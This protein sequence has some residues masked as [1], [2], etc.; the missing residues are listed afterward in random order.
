[1]NDQIQ[2]KIFK[3]DNKLKNT[4]NEDKNNIYRKKLQKYNELQHE[5]QK[6]NNNIDM[7][8][9]TSYEIDDNEGRVENDVYDIY[10]T[11]K[12][13]T[14]GIF[15]KIIDNET[16]LFGPDNNDILSP[17]GEMV[18]YDIRIDN[19]E[20]KMMGL[21]IYLPEPPDIK[22]IQNNYVPAPYIEEMQYLATETGVPIYNNQDSLKLGERGPTIME[23]FH[24]RQKIRHFD[25]EQIPE[26]VVHARGSG[27]YGTF[28]CTK[29]MSDY[30]IANF[31][32]T[33]GKKTPVF[34]R[35]SQ[36]VGSKGSSDTVRDVRGFAT[37]FYTEEGNF[38]IVGND[39]P[40]F[41]I[42][43]SIK[44]PDV[45]HAIKPEPDSAMPQAT[46]AHDNFWDF[47]SLTPETAHM[48]MWVISDIGVM[49]SYRTMEGAGVHSFKFVRKDGMAQ[50]VK[51]HWKPHLGIE[52]LS[53]EMQIK[54][55]GRDVDYLRRDLW[56]A[57]RRGFY[58][59][60]DFVVQLM[61]IENENDYLF[62]PLDPT[63]IWPE[64]LFPMIKCGE[65]ILNRNPSNFF[66]EVEQSAFHIGNI[67]PGIDFSDDPLLQGRL[68]SYDDTQLNRFHSANFNEIPVNRPIAKVRNNQ[69]DGFNRIRINRGPVN[70]EPNT[71]AKNQPLPGE[72]IDKIEHNR[73][74]KI[75]I[76]GNNILKGGGM[77]ISDKLEEKNTATNFWK[78]SKN[79]GCPFRYGNQDNR[80]IIPSL[81]DHWKIRLRSPKFQDHFSQATSRYL[82]MNNKQKEHLINAFHFE[83]GHVQSLQIRRNMI[84]FLNKIHPD[85]AQKIAQRLVL[86]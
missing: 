36:V 81:N 57:I 8:T 23:D 6:E 65:L 19:N 20:R 48:I 54:T 68:F 52:T 66:A 24:F 12:M 82:A 69:R 77:V 25:H 16:M 15:T 32:Q 60:W 64:K 75:E 39:I 21:E 56:E 55:M 41:F 43:D 34:V 27:A 86:E 49:R 2:Y 10:P 42:Q 40:V 26:R 35:F 14:H 3:Y 72:V 59:K 37:K 4:K 47:I 67:V 71:R 74:H 85:L 70:Y 22:H 80:C 11:N 73:D 84:K 62:D 31:L 44:F 51:F 7:I 58:P 45:V 13:Y 17:D 78:K 50:Y 18:A 63:K 9:K 53:N 29:S 1:M 5:S 83:L 30:T 33:E 79:I 46:G 28:T 61:P 38:D 76:T